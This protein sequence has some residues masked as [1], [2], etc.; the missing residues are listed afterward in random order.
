MALQR[1]QPLRR[2]GRQHAQLRPPR[3]TG[4]AIVTPTH[5]LVQTIDRQT[6][7]LFDLEKDPFEMKNLVGE[8]AALEKELLAQMHKRGKE[9]DDPFPRLSTPAKAFYTDE[10]AAQARS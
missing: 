4:R 10:E 9:I 1:L 3:R 7:A 2:S 6:V 5:K 8:R